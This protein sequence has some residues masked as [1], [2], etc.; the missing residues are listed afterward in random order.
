MQ[1]TSTSLNKKR[2]NRD[3]IIPAI[4]IQAALSAFTL[5]RVRCLADNASLPLK[6][7]V[8]ASCVFIDYK[9]IDWQTNQAFGSVRFIL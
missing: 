3:D 1:R 6:Q 5:R 8:D 2:E 7:G 9:S 4:M